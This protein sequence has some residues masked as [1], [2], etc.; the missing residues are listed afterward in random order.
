MLRSHRLRRLAWLPIALGACADNAPTTPLPTSRDVTADRGA[1]T[2]RND[3][4]V[5]DSVAVAVRA[6]YGLPAIAVALIRPHGRPAVAVDGVR[7]L[8]APDAV[9]TRD[10]WHLGSNTKAMTATM[11]AS[12]V[13]DGTLAW[14]STSGDVFPEL[15]PTMNPE[16]RGVT[17]LQLLSHHAGVRADTTLADFDSLPPFAG[18][19]AAQR[20]AYARRV[21]E[22]APSFPVGTFH[23]SNVGYTIATAMAERV[24]GRSWEQLMRERVLEKLGTRAVVGWPALHDPDQPWGHFEFGG[25]LIPHDPASLSLPAIIAPAGD[26]SMSVEDYA[27]FVQAHLR[28]LLGEHRLLRPEL[29]QRLHTPVGD[30]YALGWALQC[31]TDACLSYHEGSAGTFDAL[32]VILPSRGVASVAITNAASP[33]AA[34]ATA[35]AALY[36]LGVRP[37]KER[38]LP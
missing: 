4:H 9:T 1:S 15:R 21:L 2:N 35:E 31:I 37:A 34:A 8:G 26:L 23:Y 5:V 18:N 17:L 10:L 25:Q 27:V 7:R 16:L 19:P 11:I 30:G 3:A 13:K 6:K 14:T 32:T 28:G 22:G 12:L 20:L 24:T 29:V 36:L 38:E 33:A